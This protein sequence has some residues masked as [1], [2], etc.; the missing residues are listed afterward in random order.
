[1]TELIRE[2]IKRMKQFRKVVRNAERR[3]DEVVRCKDE[4]AVER[5]VVAYLH[6]KKIRAGTIEA[7]RTRSLAM[8]IWRERDLTSSPE[9]R[10]ERTPSIETEEEI[11]EEPLD[12]KPNKNRKGSAW[13]EADRYSIDGEYE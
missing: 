12:N 9:V 4:S 10:S 11:V 8:T 2:E 5:F 1:M 3:I 13:I 6:A 7:A